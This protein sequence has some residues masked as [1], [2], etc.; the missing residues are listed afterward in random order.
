M[1]VTGDEAELK[2]KGRENDAAQNP[3]ARCTGFNTGCISDKNNLN[4]EQFCK[5]FFLFFPPFE[6]NL[7][8]VSQK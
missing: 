6:Q 1:G 8:I 2:G 7:H 3:L 4:G 5:A